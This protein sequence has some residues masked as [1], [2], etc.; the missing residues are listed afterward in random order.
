MKPAPFLAPGCFLQDEGR[1]AGQGAKTELESE[2]LERLLFLQSSN[3]AAGQQ[4]LA[5]LLCPLAGLREVV[6]VGPEGR[7]QGATSARK[8]AVE[9]LDAAA[10]RRA[11]ML[12]SSGALLLPPGVHVIDQDRCRS[13]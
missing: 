1:Q 8:Y 5:A 6:E 10:C 11:A 7:P 13:L 4:E 3:P 12:L 9:F 2:R